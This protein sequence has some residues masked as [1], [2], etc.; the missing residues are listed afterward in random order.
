VSEFVCI[1]KGARHR[2]ECASR[3]QRHLMRRHSRY[4]QCVATAV[5]R[6]ELLID[7]LKC[8]C[9]KQAATR[10]TVATHQFVYRRNVN[11]IKGHGFPYTRH[12]GI[13]AEWRYTPMVL[14]LG[15]FWRP[16]VSP[17]PRPLDPRGECPQHPLNRDWPSTQSSYGRFGRERHLVPRCD[18]TSVCPGSAGT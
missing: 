10:A 3:Q 11:G 13:L 1:L 17:T 16:A 2:C 9:I 7:M 15:N 6:T 12:L 4:E 14:K 8:W 5:A 18:K